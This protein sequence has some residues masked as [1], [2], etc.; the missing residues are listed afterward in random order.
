VK[1]RVVILFGGRSAEHEVSVVSARSV[2]AALDPERYEAIP[3][4][5]T[6]QGRWVPLPGGPP[7]LAAGSTAPA[8]PGVA[9]DAEGEVAMDQRPG[10][11]ALLAPDGSRTEID[12]V[13]P[14]MHG[15]HGEDGSIQGFLE[16]AGVPYVGSGVL[17][18]AVGMDKAVQKVLF[19][20]AG[21][22][23][24]PHEVVH[25]RDWE[26]DPEAVEARAEH[27]GYPLFAKPAALGSSVGITKVAEAAG[28]RG[29]LEEAFGFGRK[30]VLE[31]S[32]EGA[33]ELEVAVLGNDEP[34]ASVAGE[35]VP[36]GHAFYDYDAKYLD[37]HGAELIVPAELDRRTLEEIRRLAVAAFRA[38]DGAGMARVDFFLT[39]EGGLLLN[40]INTIPGFTSISMYPKLWEASGVPY[41]ALVDRLI[42]L[43]LERHEAE[44]KRG[45]GA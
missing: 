16:M 5:V 25:E 26:E 38:I 10:A 35:I 21:I 31:R 15:P 39:A 34:V 20:A 19:A 17:A 33:R 36:S 28:L 22:P 44:R 23:V 7:A 4:G 3:V 30:A 32:V 18:S 2:L 6:R 13:F 40:E 24:V 45:T 29:A 14:V 1:R 11:H 27:L 12:V 37:E 43:A 42:E 8:L 41:P 9:D